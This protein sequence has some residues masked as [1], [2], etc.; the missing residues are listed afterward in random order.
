MRI[1]HKTFNPMWGTLSTICAI[2]EEDGFMLSH[3]V[4]SNQYEAVAV[5]VKADGADRVSEEDEPGYL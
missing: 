3:I 1:R 4:P 5:F 2:Q